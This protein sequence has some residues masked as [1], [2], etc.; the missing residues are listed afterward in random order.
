[1]ALEEAMR[2][3]RG[4]G[5]EDDVEGGER[6]QEVFAVYKSSVTRGKPHPGDI[7]EASSLR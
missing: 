4:A 5:A 3:V 6:V 7:A 1:M 2:A